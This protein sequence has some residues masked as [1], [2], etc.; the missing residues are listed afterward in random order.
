MSHQKLEHMTRAQ[1]VAVA[2]K[3]G[4]TDADNYTSASLVAYIRARQAEG[5]R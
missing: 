1:L 3:K 5:R 4:L 2:I